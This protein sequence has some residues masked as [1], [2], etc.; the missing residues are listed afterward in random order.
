MMR[1]L[2][3]AAIFFLLSACSDYVEELPGGYIFISESK[4][5]KWIEPE[6]ARTGDPYIPCTVE[7]HDSN[8]RFI[9]ARQRPTERCVAEGENPMAHLIGRE[10]FWI[11]DVRTHTFYGPYGRPEFEAKRKELAVPPSL[12]V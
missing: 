6:N 10:F 3:L 8:A 9:V 1:R 2:G 11:I 7:A 5:Q 12:E 4:D